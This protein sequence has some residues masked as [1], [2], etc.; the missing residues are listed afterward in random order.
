MTLITIILAATITITIAKTMTIPILIAALTIELT[1]SF[2]PRSHIITQAPQ[3]P[4]ELR[5]I[6]MLMAITITTISLWMAK[7]RMW[8]RKKGKRRN[9]TTDVSVFFSLIPI[10]VYAF[11]LFVLFTL[12]FVLLYRFVLL[13]FCFPFYRFVSRLLCSISLLLCY[14]LFTCSLCICILCLRFCT[15]LFNAFPSFVR[16]LACFYFSSFTPKHTARNNVF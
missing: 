7:M 2:S 15:F 9:R 3:Q 12:Y 5:S 16:A 8:M 13:C 6:S 4:I 11:V 1:A 14:F 10:S